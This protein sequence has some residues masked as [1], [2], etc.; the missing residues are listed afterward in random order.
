M[1]QAWL[2]PSLVLA[3][4]AA[5]V[6]QLVC[7]M[8]LSCVSHSDCSL[9]CAWEAARP[10]GFRQPCEIPDSGTSCEYTHN[11]QNLQ[12]NSMLACITCMHDSTPT[13]M[14]VVHHLMY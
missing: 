5:A 2:C 9:V 8:H 3:A 6:V 14:H 13:S 10:L 4:A 7:C 11:D 1:Q 12:R